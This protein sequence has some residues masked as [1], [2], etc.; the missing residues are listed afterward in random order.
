MLGLWS[1]AL[2]RTSSGTSA[3]KG[4]LDLASPWQ[5][6]CILVATEGAEVLFYWTDKEFE[7]RLRLKFGQSENEGEE[8]SA[9]QEGGEGTAQNYQRARRQEER[10]HPLDAVECS[11]PAPL[12]APELPVLNEFRWW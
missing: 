5:M 8:V 10:P 2:L 7:E 12:P 11:D 6:K 1:F 9:G 4:D 3:L